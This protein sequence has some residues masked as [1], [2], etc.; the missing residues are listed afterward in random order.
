MTAEPA[1][2]DLSKKLV[3]AAG[4]L[5]NT[6]A[7]GEIETAARGLADSLRVR[8][9]EYDNQTAL[10]QGGVPGALNTVAKAAL[11]SS[12]T[13]TPEYL[14]ALY[15]VLRVAANLCMDHDENRQRL[16]DV[17]FPQAIVSLLEA[18]V[19][20]NQSATYA[21]PQPLSIPELK[22]I[23]TSMGVLVNATVGYEPVKSVLV[24]SAHTILRLSTSVYPPGS[25]LEPIA[26]DLFPKDAASP[27]EE[28]IRESWTLRSG[29]SSWAWRA[30]GELKEDS[31]PIFE[32]TALPELTRPLRSFDSSQPSDVPAL[33]P[34]ALAK[35]LSAIDFE[36]FEESCS[37]LEGL[38][39]DDEDARLSL[40]RGLMNPDEHGGTACLTDILTFIDSGTHHPLWS[41]LESQQEAARRSKAFD[42]CK[43]AL[44]KVVV[45]VAGEEKNTDVLWDD[46]DASAPG[47]AFVTRIVRWIQ[48]N[49]YAD[50]SKPSARDDLVI[51]ATLALGNLVRHEAHSL[52]IVSSP[53]GIGP[54][55][56]AILAPDADMKVKHGAIGLLRHLAY[57]PGT[58]APLA[59]ARII[60]RL[61]ESGIFNESADIAET[62]QVNAI[63]VVKN[64]VSGNAENTFAFVL[65]DKLAD[66][67]SS[68]LRL[69][70]ALIGRSDKTAI[71]SEGTRVLINAARTL[72]SSAAPEGDARRA[73]MGAMTSPDVANALAQLIGR[74]KKY[75][76]LV[77]EGVV[78][79]TL[80]SLT[81]AGANLVLDALTIPL[82]AEAPAPQPTASI[83]DPDSATV[84]S[85]TAAPG[86][87]FDMLV[88]V[89]RAKSKRFPE[90]IC[91]NTCLLLGQVSKPVENDTRKEERE[92]FVQ[93]V[94]PLL[95][96]EANREGESRLKAAAGKAL[97]MVV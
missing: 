51:C 55:L 97:A 40:A 86:R 91:I 64:L 90:E 34:Q 31:E 16:L 95:E 47:G 32:T 82:P 29:L 80:L 96:K 46:S 62:V 72:W 36:I 11:S 14:P 60:P 73:A 30:L 27:S 24:E 56:A 20:L 4:S 18:Y 74:S 61:L 65:D 28:D 37:T 17:E 50:F 77:N 58:R 41:A 13:P 70:L 45:E 35:S 3:A 84:M 71:K 63:G 25:W 67:P 7:L 78:G 1:V 92:R 43:A 6:A 93:E 9:P 66:S 42:M 21:T 57:T 53:I 48:E 94:K 81:P 12:A 76:L 10:G 52:A 2:L 75:P 68:G 23:K 19:N 59:G 26:R 15:E 87:A 83:D 39:M 38:V 8:K 88:Y 85:P 89:L 69:L 79:L 44:V 5:L 33:F 49:A 54:A 22:V